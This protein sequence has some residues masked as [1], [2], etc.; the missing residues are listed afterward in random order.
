VL[1]AAFLD[2]YKITWINSRFLEIKYQT[3]RIHH[4]QNNWSYGERNE[5][6]YEIELRL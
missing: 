6:P 2:G 3:G 4:F 5:L 1:S